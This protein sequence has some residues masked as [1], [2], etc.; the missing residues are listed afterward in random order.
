MRG[1]LTGDVVELQQCAHGRES[2]SA[3]RY[4]GSPPSTAK[5][6]DAT[7]VGE[8]KRFEM[9]STTDAAFVED[10][11]VEQ[12]FRARVR[13]LKKANKSGARSPGPDSDNE[14]APLL[15]YSRHNN[16]GANSDGIDNEGEE[17]WAGDADFRGLPW[18]KRPS[19][20]VTS[21][22]TQKSLADG[23]RYSG[24]CRPSYCS[25]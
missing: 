6:P 16:G 23:H 2:N 21:P 11:E 5:T 3:P 7:R 22:C 15:G 12:E 24:Y 25:P 13:N 8:H 17:E 19:V 4:P 10:I 20:R 14:D 9:A 18:W 1:R